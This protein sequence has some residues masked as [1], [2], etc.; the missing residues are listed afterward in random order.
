ML[1]K[2]ALV[3]IALGAIYY[4]YHSMLKSKGCSCGKDDCCDKK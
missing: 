1:E 2:V 3:I 4:I